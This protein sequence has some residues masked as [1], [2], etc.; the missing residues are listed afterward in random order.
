MLSFEETITHIRL[1]KKGDNNSKEILIKNNIL[2]VKSIVNR[3]KNKGVDYDDL[4]QI[5]S[6]LFPIIL[7]LF[8]KSFAI[9]RL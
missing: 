8:Q 2:L 9:K 1:A 5:A 6:I 3:F 7:Y 4:F